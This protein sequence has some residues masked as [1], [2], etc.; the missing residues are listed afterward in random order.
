MARDPFTLIVALD[1]K[2]RARGDLYVDDGRS[3]AFLR[4]QYAHLE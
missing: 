1:D 3:F 2:G 4:G